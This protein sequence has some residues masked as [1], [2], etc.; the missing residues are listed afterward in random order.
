MKR[1]I[2]LFVAAQLM[3]S[4]S[5]FAQTNTRPVV[6]AGVDK[7]LTAGTTSVTLSGSA[8]DADGTI[9]KYA[10]SKVKGPSFS[11]T[12]TDQPTVTVTNLHKG[13]YIFRLTVT[14]NSTDANTNTAY[15]EVVVIYDQPV[16]KKHTKGGTA[17]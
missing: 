15:D 17:T 10:W 3:L 1:L 9:T 11:W 16:V 7:K 6:T 8:S 14:D 4:S 12:N 5:V 13:I 2:Y